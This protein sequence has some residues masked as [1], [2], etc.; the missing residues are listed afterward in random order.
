ML[1]CSARHPASLFCSI[2]LVLFQQFLWSCFAYW[3]PLYSRG[4]FFFVCVWCY[5]FFCI[6]NSWCRTLFKQAIVCIFWFCVTRMQGLWCLDWVCTN[7]ATCILSKPFCALL[8]S[9]LA[10]FTRTKQVSWA[11]PTAKRSRKLTMLRACHK[12]TSMVHNFFSRERFAFVT[13]LHTL[14]ST[15]C[16]ACILVGFLFTHTSQV[17][18]KHKGRFNISLCK[19]QFVGNVLSIKKRVGQMWMASCEFLFLR[20]EGHVFFRR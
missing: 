3:A 6:S 15:P 2:L 11:V 12:T 17:V 19:T 1:S 4:R 18:K 10:N 8:D 16:L 9:T 14:C 7:T 5:L 13:L 20:A